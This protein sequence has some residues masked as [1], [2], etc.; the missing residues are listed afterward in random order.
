MKKQLMNTFVF[1]ALVVG[2][3]VMIFP[4]YYMFITSLKQ[5]AYVFTIPPQLIPKPATF[6]NYAFI[7]KEADFGQYFLNS[8]MITIPGVLLNVFLSAL[9]AYGF[10][11][12]RFP[13]KEMVFSL[14]IAT[15]SVPGLLLIIPQFQIISKFKFLMDNKLTVILTA[16]I[17][18]IAFNAFFLRGFFEGLPKEIEESAEIDGCNAFQIFWHIV[19]PMARPAI[20][21]LAIMS[22]LGIWDDYFWPSLI[23]Q[24]KH[25][26]TL[27][28]GIMA[29]K[30]QHT[31]RWNLIFAGTMIAVVPVIIIYFLLQKYFV[32]TVAEGGLKF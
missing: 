30:G 26:W 7:W 32:K 16:G 24:S 18:G 27:P 13:L 2:A 25:N 6:E 8:V 12:Y 10:A 17:S 22:F 5:A 28:I 4:F 14:L 11:R 20:A 21:T 9:T 23:L 19:I 31:V 3:M 1:A 29:L 15:L